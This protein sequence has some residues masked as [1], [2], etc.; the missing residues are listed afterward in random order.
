M[1]NSNSYVYNV[2]ITEY[3]KYIL[4]GID[5]IKLVRMCYQKPFSVRLCLNILCK[6]FNNPLIGNC[7]KTQCME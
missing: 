5:N 2:G 1:Q 7:G 3:A 6:I 4:G